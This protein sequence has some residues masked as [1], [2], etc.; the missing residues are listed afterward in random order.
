[1]GILD[2]DTMG[3]DTQVS[4]PELPVGVHPNDASEPVA[5]GFGRGDQMVP[6]DT[7]GNRYTTGAPP[8]ETSNAEATPVF[9]RASHDFTVQVVQVNALPVGFA[10][11]AGRTKGRKAVTLSV[12][13][14]LSNGAAPLGVVYGPTQDAVEG[15]GLLAVLNVGDSVTIA[16]EAQIFIGCIPGNNSGV[17]QVLEEINPPGGA[18]GTG[19]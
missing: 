19:A 15:P 18:L 2:Q 3:D 14:L 10:I 16:T 1:M 7:V 8:W 17:C 13:S 11:A 6:D 5:P 4:D 12:P 9:E